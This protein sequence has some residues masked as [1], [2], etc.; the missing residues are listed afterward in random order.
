MSTPGRFKIIARHK[1]ARAGVLSTPHGDIET[2]I[3]MPVGTVGSVKALSPEDLQQ[4]GAQIIL[5]NTYHLN[6]RPTSE[7]IKDL[8]GLHKFMNWDGPILTDSGGF[9]AFSLGAMIA[10]GIKKT[11]SKTQKIKAVGKKGGDLRGAPSSAHSIA[12]T[13]DGA[14]SQQ[15]PFYFQTLAL[16]PRKSEAASQQDPE[17]PRKVF[18][19]ITDEGVVF[20]SHIDGSKHFLSPERSIDIQQNLG[21][22]I[23]LVLDELLSPTA[24]SKY[25]QNSLDRTHRWEIA[26]L[27]H[28]RKN[29]PQ[30]INPNAL[31][32]G[33]VQGVQDQTIRESE[34]KWAAK[35]T[36]DG[37]SIGGSMGSPDDWSATHAIQQT[38]DWVIPHLPEQWPK[39]ALGIGEIADLFNCVELGIDMFDC[40]APTRRARNGSLYLSPKNGGNTKNKFTLNISNVQFALDQSPIDPNCQCYT[41]QNFSRAY[42]RHLYMAKELL[43]HRLATIHNVYFCLNLTRQIRQSIQNSTFDELKSTWLA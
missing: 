18:A 8:G 14:A 27:K 21:S 3:F 2:P 4:A 35:Q 30:S 26:S 41:C 39:H 28:F 13:S 42:L 23:C 32:F 34:A 38:M 20:K 19:K 17:K 10:D 33:I 7:L 5:G 12:R 29:A 37:I 6:L 22:D 40:V 43:F 9:Q 24:D 15:N 31:I 36:F 25:I 1:K 16:D 11:S